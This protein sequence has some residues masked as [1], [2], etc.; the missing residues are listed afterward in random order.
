MTV[1]VSASWNTQVSF[2]IST[3]LLCKVLGF[4]MTKN[5]TIRMKT[6]ITMED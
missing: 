6:E 3:K 2:R 1:P 4:K 5:K